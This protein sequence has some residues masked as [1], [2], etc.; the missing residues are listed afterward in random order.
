MKT[1]NYQFRKTFEIKFWGEIEAKSEKDAEKKIRKFAE[2]CHP[3]EEPYDGD[4]SADS[5]AL[6]K[7]DDFVIYKEIP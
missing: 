7:G 5:M 2:T 1:F 4:A 3:G 6:D